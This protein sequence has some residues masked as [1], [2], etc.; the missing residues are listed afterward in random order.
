MATHSN[1]L[2]S[3]WTE[4]PGRLQAIGL[5]RVGRN[6]KDLVKHCKSI[7]LQF[8]N[9]EYEYVQ[10]SGLGEGLTN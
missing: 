9:T 3:P 1:F 10:V 6:W 5:Q 7:I 4:E 2:S 8:L